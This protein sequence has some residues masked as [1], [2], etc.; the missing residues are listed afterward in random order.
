MHNRKLT[1]TQIYM[2][3]S[4]QPTEKAPD[5]ALL[6]TFHHFLIKILTLPELWALDTV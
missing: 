1:F 3:A 6:R 5:F 2:H 4:W